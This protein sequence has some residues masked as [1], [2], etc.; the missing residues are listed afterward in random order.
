M[1]SQPKSPMEELE[2]MRRVIEALDGFD[3]EAVRR[4]LQWSGAQFGVVVNRESAGGSTPG[5]GEGETQRNPPTSDESGIT[6]IADL[7]AEA[8]PTN[9][10]ESAL[11]VAYWLQ[12]IGGQAEFDARSLNDE[13]KHLGRPLA[14]VTTTLS[15]LISQRPSLLMQTQ[16]IGRG[17]QGRKR[18]KLTQPGINRVRR[19]LAEQQKCENGE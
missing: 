6:A 7:F 17:A 1:E 9:G 18:Y 8:S 2:A 15:S 4:I 12:V 5:G 10:P 13:L 14:N 11:V 3:A 19:M 16:K